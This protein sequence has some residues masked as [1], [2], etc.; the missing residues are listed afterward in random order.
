LV[1]STPLHEI[2]V[3]GIED[4]NDVKYEFD[5]ETETWSVTA[6]D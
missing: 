2:L 4:L 6:V 3:Y 5:T 1:S